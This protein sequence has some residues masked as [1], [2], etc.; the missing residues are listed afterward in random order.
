[1]DFKINIETPFNK[2]F[3]QIDNLSSSDIFAVFPD[4]LDQEFFGEIDIQ[5]VSNKLIV[6]IQILK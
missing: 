4:P 6:K 1:M 5:L 3:R 2:P